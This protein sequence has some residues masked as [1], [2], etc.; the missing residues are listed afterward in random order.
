MHHEPP[1]S[2]HIHDL[3][4]EMFAHI[5]YY[6]DWYVV[7]AQFVCRTWCDLLREHATTYL[8]PTG[9][10]YNHTHVVDKLATYDSLPLMIWARSI[11]IPMFIHMPA[12]IRNRCENVAVWCYCNTL[13]KY[14]HG[15]DGGKSAFMNTFNFAVNAGCFALAKHLYSGEWRIKIRES[16]IRD[17]LRSGSLAMMQW[18]HEKTYNTRIE[19]SHAF[20]ELTTRLCASQS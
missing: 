2:L 10:F 19:H 9:P 8:T 6:V 16:H 7:I 5:F 18:I 17:V 1:K 13:I 12:I 3:P 4:M 15:P 11:G 20:R 14:S